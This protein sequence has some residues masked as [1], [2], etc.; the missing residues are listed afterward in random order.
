MKDD[1]VDILE[2]N[3]EELIDLYEETLKNIKYL[4]DSILE[5][6]EGTTNE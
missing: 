3:N 4:N 6:S 2:L 5:E 1:I